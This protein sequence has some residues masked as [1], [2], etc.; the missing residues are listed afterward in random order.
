[1]SINLNGF[2]QSWDVV[3]GNTAATNEYEFWKG[4]VMSTGQ[5]LNNQFDF[6]TYH[7]TTRYEWFKALQG[8]YPDVWDEYTF[9][10]NTNDPRIFDFKTF[11]QY[12]GEYLVG[13]PVTPTPTPTN[14]PT[15]TPTPVGTIEYVAIT[16]TDISYSYE[17]QDWYVG[18]NTTGD[19]LRSR[20]L[21]YN[22]SRWLAGCSGGS[23]II[24]SDDSINWSGTNASS[25][26]DVFVNSIIWNGS[27]WFAG[28]RSSNV[29]A[30]STDGINWTALTDASTY[31]SR[32]FQLVYDGT[33]IVAAGWDLSNTPQVASTN[34]GGNTW[35]DIVTLGTG[36]GE[37]PTS[38]TYSS[39]LGLYVYTQ[40]SGFDN[41]YI[42]N[43]RVNWSAVT[44]SD[45]SS[46]SSYSCGWDGTKF[47]LGNQYNTNPLFYSYDGIDWSGSTNGDYFYV[48]NDLHWDGNNWYAVGAGGDPGEPRMAYSTDGISWTG[49]TNFPSFGTNFTSILSKNSP[50]LIPPI[51]QPSPTPTPIPPTPTPSPV[52]GDPDATAYLAAVV[53][54]GGTVDSTIT[55]ATNTLFEDLK[56]AGIYSKLD[57]FYPMIG[58]TYNSI[59]IEGKLQTSY[60]LTEGGSW[61][62]GVSG[63]TTTSNTT[64]NS[65]LDTGFNPSTLS[66]RADTSYSHYW[67]NSYSMTPANDRYFA[68]SYSSGNNMWAT[69]PYDSS[70]WQYVAYVNSTQLSAFNPTST[71]ALSGGMFISSQY[72][73]SGTDYNSGWINT[74]ASSVVTMAGAGNLPNS[75]FYFGNLS[76]NNSPYQG[77]P[78]TYSF[79]HI[80]SSL[81]NSEMSDLADIVNAFQ[82]T[83]GRN[84]Y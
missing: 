67:V 71:G 70:N 49:I 56:S 66:T 9:Y 27:K 51:P 7:N 10:K 42:S 20:S 30:E 29:F 23:L 25:V 33:N 76:L 41:V 37:V 79:G 32:I 16:N 31:F 74:V 14:T 18:N 26:F 6:F 61:T 54:A 72:S 57:V 83:L 60:Y 68:G 38:L 43:D 48:V 45:V 36:S 62:Y 21:V 15:P 13:T 80:G 17:G 77:I 35:T 22:G 81:T 40:Q 75:N 1:M 34:D 12:C 52:A 19:S 8:T 84:V 11:Y 3:S 59:R 28:G 53:S 5:V 63:A 4:M 50:E 24:Y 64:H 47:V 55:S 69:N 58:G 46:N 82:T 65:Y 44:N 73:S 39:D 2:W 78:G